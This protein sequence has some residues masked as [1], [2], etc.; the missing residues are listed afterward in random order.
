MIPKI[1]TPK[2]QDTI[3]Q[4]GDNIW[5]LDQLDLGE[6]DKWLGDQQQQAA[7]KLLCEYSGIFSKNDLDLGK[8][9]I[10]KYDIKWTDHQPFKEKYRRIPPHLY[11]EVKQQLPRNGR[12]W[13]N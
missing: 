8:C 3:E 1:Q 2:E 9:N 6:I 12:N 10:L 7:K 5:I 11:E 13:C 4:R